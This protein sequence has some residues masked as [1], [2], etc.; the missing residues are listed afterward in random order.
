MQLAPAGD[1]VLQSIEIIAKVGGEFHES[2]KLISETRR[3]FL[4]GNI[5]ST[6]QSD[7]RKTKMSNQ[8]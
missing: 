5:I 3:R 7:E 4:H 6:K 1:L 8:W 2:F